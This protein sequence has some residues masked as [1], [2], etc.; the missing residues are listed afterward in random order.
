MLTEAQRQRGDKLLS[1]AKD[2]READPADAR[3]GSESGQV[4]VPEADPAKVRTQPA[5]ESGWSGGALQIGS[6]NDRRGG[7]GVT[8]SSRPRSSSR[9][10]F[11]TIRN[12]R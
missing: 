2:G 4:L 10:A 8:P 6:T 5:S 9:L 12:S 7:S 3:Y 11:S 1:I